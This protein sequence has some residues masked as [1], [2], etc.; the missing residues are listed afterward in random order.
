M[1]SRNN[2][3]IPIFFFCL[4]SCS[5][6]TAQSNIENL[7][8]CSENTSIQKLWIFNEHYAFGTRLKTNKPWQIRDIILLNDKRLFS[9]SISFNSIFRIPSDSFIDIYD[10]VNLGDDR[11]LVLHGYGVSEIEIRNYQIRLINKQI[12]VANELQKELGELIGSTTL[13]NN[14]WIIGYQR[15]K[16]RKG[17]FSKNDKDNFPYY[18]VLQNHSDARP[19]FINTD[20]KSK[21][22]DLFLPDDI[23]VIKD[24]TNYFRAYIAIT[25]DFIVF[26]SPRSN[27]CYFFSF[28]DSSVSVLKFPEC[29]KGESNFLFTDSNLRD[30]YIVRK[31]LSKQ[32]NIFK[33]SSNRHSMVKIGEIEYLPK[34]FVEGKVYYSVEEKIDNKKAT[35]HYL[36]SFN[37]N[38]NNK[39]ILLEEIR[40]QN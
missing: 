32:Y 27:E 38:D 11:F 40:V 26:N 23:E 3:L 34:G 14:N 8:Y 33:L 4:L 1:L 6:V 36:K 21:C 31:T 9:D 13:Y 30:S 2:H 24:K 7:F 20:A 16:Y 19:L 25:K 35:C 12:Q 22:D 28:L 5:N 17:T 39:P 15:A 18:W 10:I 29:K 37:E